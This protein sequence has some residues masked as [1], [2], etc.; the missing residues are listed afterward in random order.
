MS[1]LPFSKKIITSSMQQCS[2]IWK[3]KI[4]GMTVPFKSVIGDQQAAFWGKEAG[5]GVLHSTLDL[6]IGLC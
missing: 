4:D 1:T 2:V 5:S 3:I 6:R